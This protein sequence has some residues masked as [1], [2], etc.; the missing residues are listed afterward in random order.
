MVIKISWNL[1]LGN[2]LVIKIDLIIQRNLFMISVDYNIYFH[3][4][5]FISLNQCCSFNITVFNRSLDVLY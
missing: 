1:Y 2:V 5:D 4:V 3:S